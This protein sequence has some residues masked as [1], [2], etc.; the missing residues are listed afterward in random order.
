MVTKKELED[1]VSQVNSVLAGLDERIKKLENPPP[2]TNR[3][4]KQQNSWLLLT[5]MV[6]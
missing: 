1:L 2:S 5:C 3:A 4:K 6:E